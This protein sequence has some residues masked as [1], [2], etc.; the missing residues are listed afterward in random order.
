[1]SAIV[2]LPFAY[3]AGALAVSRLVLRLGMHQYTTVPGSGGW[4][5]VGIYSDTLPSP[6]KIDQVDRPPLAG[7]PCLSVAVEGSAAT[8]SALTAAPAP[9]VGRPS[10][11]GTAEPEN[12]KDDG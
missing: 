10:F 4:G 1:L 11:S 2:A 7:V 6:K 3:E 9:R 8:H 12:R 5:S